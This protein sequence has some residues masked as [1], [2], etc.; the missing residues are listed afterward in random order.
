MTI[1]IGTGSSAVE[2]S[3]LRMGSGPAKRVM[4]G[5]GNDAVPVWVY[6]APPMEPLSFGGGRTAHPGY[7]KT[8][9]LVTFYVEHGGRA[10]VH[11]K[12]D[13]P[14]V[15]YHW[16]EYLNRYFGIMNPEFLALRYWDGPNPPDTPWIV[17]EITGP[18]R[19][20]DNT[21]YTIYLRIDADEPMERYLNSWSVDIIPVV[22]AVD[23]STILTVSPAEAAWGDPVTLTATVTPSNAVGSVTFDGAGETST[24][25]LVDGV[26]TTTRTFYTPGEYEVSAEFTP[27]SEEDFLPSSGTSSITV[28]EGALPVV[29]ITG[30]NWSESRNQLLDALTARGLD[31]ATVETLPFDLDTSQATSLRGLFELYVK[32]TEVPEMDTSNVTDMSN[33]FSY[34]GSLTSVPEMDTSNVTDM[35]GMFSNTKLTSVPEMDTSQ[36]TNMGTMFA[37]NSSLVEVPEMDTSNVTNMGYMFSWCTALTYVP[38][39]DTSNVTSMVSMLAGTQSLTDGNIRLFGRHPDVDTT[40]MIS[41]SGLTVEPFFVPAV[42]TTTTLAVVPSEITEGESIS[43]TATVTP[44]DAVGSVTFAVAG[45]TSTVV[46]VN[47]TATGT[48]T[49]DQVGEHE[50]TADFVPDDELDFLPSSGTGSLTV[51]EFVPAVE[52]TTT[53]SVVPNEITEGEQVILTATVTPNEAVGEVT[54]TVGTQ[55]S[56]VALAGGTASTTLT[57]D[58]PGEYDI[59][60]EFVPTD[61]ADFLP[62]SDTASITVI[63]GPVETQTTLV[64]VPEELEEGELVTVTATVTPSDAAGVIEFDVAGQLSSVNVVNGEAVATVTLDVAGEHDITADFIP[65]DEADFLPSSATGSITVTEPAAPELVP[66]SWSGGSVPGSDRMA[67]YEVV[68]YTVVG[69]GVANLP[70][71]FRTSG[72]HSYN[73]TATRNMILYLNGVEIRNEEFKANNLQTHSHTFMH[74]P[75]RNG[76]V[77][78]YGVQNRALQNRSILSWSLDLEPVDSYY[79]FEAELGSGV[80]ER[81]LEEGEITSHVIQGYE[82]EVMVSFTTKMSIVTNWSATIEITQNG[83]QALLHTNYGWSAEYGIAYTLI[84]VSPGDVISVHVFMNNTDESVRAYESMTFTII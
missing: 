29:E 77:L 34:C 13:G 12:I 57:L 16:G 17:D 80:L 71:T 31:H 47:G 19:F 43:L 66:M 75:L 76:D 30:T 82:G 32:L 64:V 56:T 62:S 6:Q 38:D 3:V 21:E 44:A 63:P 81:T 65:T 37:F 5:T 36:V 42:E 58:T 22:P 83:V 27:T 4:V 40:G 15:D 70:A 18:V 55:T 33:M 46:V 74:V 10:H 72:N 35:V 45:E 50:V 52:T 9:T 39:M 84:Q 51:L 2:P 73:G 14:S 25:S 48:L 1:K 8:G 11:V 7:A 78:A 60:A 68:S 67:I 26:A 24:V 23:T 79:G 53:L 59:T 61:E 54:F 69:E 49:V 41:S 28:V 20:Q